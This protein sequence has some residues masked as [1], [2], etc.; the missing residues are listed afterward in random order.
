MT[1]FITATTGNRTGGRSEKSE[2][3]KVVS[4]DRLAICPK[5]YESDRTTFILSKET[6]VSLSDFSDR[7]PVR[8]PVVVVMNLVREV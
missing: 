6:T 7:P 2:S 3:A 8:F 5:I 1:R 4:L